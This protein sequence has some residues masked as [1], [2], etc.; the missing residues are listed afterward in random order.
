RDGSGIA[1]T[2]SQKDGLYLGF[3]VLEVERSRCS[4]ELLRR[5]HAARWDHVPDRGDAPFARTASHQHKRGPHPPRVVGL[6]PS[7][8]VASVRNRDA[9]SE[10]ANHFDRDL[11]RARIALRRRQRATDDVV[12]SPAP[13][14]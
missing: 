5:G 7:N 11:T 10:E 9:C 13:F 3:E 1:S 4:G 2:L 8:L 12:T 14:A 6:R